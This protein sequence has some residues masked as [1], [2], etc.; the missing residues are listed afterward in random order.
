MQYRCLQ[1]T[2][3]R[4]VLPRTILYIASS[5]AVFYLRLG[6]YLCGYGCSKHMNRITPI[7]ICRAS[8]SVLARGQSLL[9]PVFG[10]PKVF[11]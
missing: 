9:F 6:E 8:L 3:V 11:C 4:H 1:S 10:L 7:L 2:R 5:K